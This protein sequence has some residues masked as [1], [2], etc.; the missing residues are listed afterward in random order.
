MFLRSKAARILLHPAILLRRAITQRRDNMRNR[1][2]ENLQGRLAEDPVVRVD[3]FQGTFLL[4][5]RSHLFARVVSEGVYEPELAG[6]CLAHLD[7]TRDAIDVGANAGFYTNLMA[8]QLKGGRVLAVEPTANALARLR[9]NIERNG[10][11]SRA[12]VFEGIASDRECM[13]TLNVIAGK[14]EY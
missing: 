14:E 1:L 7:P 6:A 9:A 13:R 3:E 11:G 4:D 10:I 12:V 8:R 5:R 2:V